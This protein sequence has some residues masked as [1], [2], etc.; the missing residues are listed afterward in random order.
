MAAKRKPKNA[1]A[2]AKT[3]ANARASSGHRVET[4]SSKVETPASRPPRIC[5]I[6][7]GCAKNTIDGETALG[8]LLGA[9][10]DLATDPVD[11]DLVLVNTCGFIESARE[12]SLS[13][14]E[15]VLADKDADGYP[16]VVAIG[17]FP[18]K[19]AALLQRRCPGLDGILGLGAY[20]RLSDALLKVLQ[21]RGQR[22]RHVHDGA[23]RRIPDGPRLLTTPPS[24]AYLRIADGCDNRC[25]YCTIPDIRGPFQ[26]RPAETILAEARVLAEGGVRELILVA[27]ETTRYGIDIEGG[28]RLTGLLDALLRETDVPRIRILYAHPAR[29]DDALLDRLAGEE[30]L[31]RYLDVPVQ[32]VT[33]RMLRAMHRGYDRAHLME[34]LETARARVPGL[35]LRSTLI[36]GFPGETEADFEG[37]LAWVASGAVEHLGAF[38]WS[39]EPDTPAFALP[40]HVPAA[41]AEERRERILEAQQR[42]AFAWMESRVQTEVEVL[43][44]GV[45]E[46]GR[47]YGRT[48]AEAPDVDGL[49][50]VEGENFSPGAQIRAC[51]MSRSG[52][53]MTARAL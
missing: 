44:D 27:Q 51:L 53:D 41:V 49:V 25:S 33:D 18:E 35:V 23:A 22:I 28:L 12:E 30:R 8:E 46:T 7:L 34:R 52:Y 17:C 20:G 9:G 36:T 3:N 21:G 45:E 43:L 37:M 6:N 38:A 19:D 48:R 32:H 26:S 24:Y 42:V 15:E 39:P 16:R 5:L 10:W 47:W 50:Y 14:I 4:T 31:C 29:V 1:N 40:D 2:K 13:V 11:A